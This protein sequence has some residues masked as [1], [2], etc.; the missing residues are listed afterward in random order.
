MNFLNL[1]LKVEALKKELSASSIK[2]A[3]TGVINKYP[4]IAWSILQHYEICGT[5][6]LDITHSLHVACSFAIDN[7]KG[8][9]GIIYVLGMPWQTDSICYK[10]YEELEIIKL[11]GISP[12]Q[13]Q[14]PFFQEG[15]LVGPFPHYKLDE[16]DRV[17]QF[18]FARRLIAK[19]EI[20][21]GPSDFWGKSGFGPIPHD[22][23][24]QVDDPIKV[25]CDR[26]KVPT[27]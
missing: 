26:I 23:L 1:K 19:F 17:K 24:Y 21:I 5:P 8:K 15:Y 6:L 2:Y 10:T 11:L 7:N 4:E 13:A 20:P 14:R 22:K 27:K 16:P 9:T 3:G 12:P 18:D 25:L